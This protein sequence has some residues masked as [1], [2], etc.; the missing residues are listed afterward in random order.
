MN[1]D[2]RTVSL[3]PSPWQQQPGEP[4]RWFGRFHLYR[5]L[6]A[7]RSIDWAWRRWIDQAKRKANK[8]GRAP[9][10]WH[11]AAKRWGWRERALAFDVDQ[12]ERVGEQVLGE[13]VRRLKDA[14]GARRWRHDLLKSLGDTYLNH[15]IEAVIP[16][17]A[18]G[19]ADALAFHNRN[20]ENLFRFT[21]RLV[22][23]NRA[24]FA[25]EERLLAE[26]A[27]RQQER[28]EAPAGLPAAAREIVAAA[29]PPT[30]LLTH[31]WHQETVNWREAA[32]PCP[33][34]GDRMALRE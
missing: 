15:L 22:A 18:E 19:R 24:E 6:G 1:P 10:S 5:E 17:S 23:L 4:P 32:P 29:P 28:V 16:L 11:R 3:C 26:V 9:D 12:V 8:N 25:A 13:R 21:E 27:S 34:G 7:G 2:E 31:G 20:L 30:R 33:A 14:V